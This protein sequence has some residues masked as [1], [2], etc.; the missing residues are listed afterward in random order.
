MLG[1]RTGLRYSYPN[2]S[3]FRLSTCAQT[4]TRS[5]CRYSRRSCFCTGTRSG[6]CTRFCNSIRFGRR[7]GARSS[8]CNGLTNSGRSCSRTRPRF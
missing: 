4:R 5:V 7:N 3:W 2:N 6:A 1:P 8:S